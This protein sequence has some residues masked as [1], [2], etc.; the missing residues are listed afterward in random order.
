MVPCETSI[1]AE[2]DAVIFVTLE[3]TMATRKPCK[4]SLYFGFSCSYL[5]NKL[6]DPI[7]F[8]YK[9]DQQATMKLSLQSL[10][11]SVERI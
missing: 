9:S 6:G 7:F 1:I 11:Y 8:L 3:V 2:Q 4:N 10:N 5:K